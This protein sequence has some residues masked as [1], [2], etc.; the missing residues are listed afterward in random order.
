MSAEHTAYGEAGYWEERYRARPEEH[1]EWYRSYA[2]L[3]PE[4]GFL[5]GQQPESPRVLIVGNG[6]SRFPADLYDDA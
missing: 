1:F 3:W 6:N 5:F 4:F 2:E